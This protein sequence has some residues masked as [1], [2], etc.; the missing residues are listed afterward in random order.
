MRSATTSLSPAN[1]SKT[2]TSLW[3]KA[4]FGVSAT[5]KLTTT[6]ANATL[7][8]ITAVSTD[9]ANVVTAVGSDLTDAVADLATENAA[10]QVQAAFRGFK[11]RQRLSQNRL[12]L[13]F[14]PGQRAAAAQRIQA[15]LRGFKIRRGPTVYDASA[16]LHG[17]AADV[18][19]PTPNHLWYGVDVGWPQQGWSV[20]GSGRTTS[21]PPE[22]IAPTLIETAALAPLQGEVIG[23]CV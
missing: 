4:K 7:S 9:V 12:L 11:D 23:E 20:P 10:T 17:L 1:A 6:S 5:R 18:S 2:A 16:M 3:R 22:H 13:R 15:H 14:N 21:V 19:L 8:T